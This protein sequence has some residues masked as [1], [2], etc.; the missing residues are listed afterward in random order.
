MLIRTKNT[1][2]V[3]KS[4]PNI[5]CSH[6]TVNHDNSLKK[7]KFKQTISNS[8]STLDEP[9]NDTTHISL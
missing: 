4:E 2:K 6:E 9:V 3:S 8:N 5:P 7:T 1:L